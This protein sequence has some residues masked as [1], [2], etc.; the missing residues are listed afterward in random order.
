MYGTI[1]FGIVEV[2]QTWPTFL[3]IKWLRNT[4]NKGDLVYGFFLSWLFIVL[5]LAVI[6]G[7]WA[8]GDPWTIELMAKNNAAVIL[9][10]VVGAIVFGFWLVSLD[11]SNTKYGEFKDE[12]I[13]V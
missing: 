2:I 7:F 4:A 3:F 12:G 6:F 9:F 10:G 5:A 13:E 8:I 1:V 11:Y